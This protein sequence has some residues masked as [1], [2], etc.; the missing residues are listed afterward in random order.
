MKDIGYGANYKYAH[1]YQGNFVD[2]EFLP[3]EIS[4]MKFYEPGDNPKERETRRFLT[5][6][7]KKYGY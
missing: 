3:A 7:W 5:E 2:Q 4:G 6:R 1:D